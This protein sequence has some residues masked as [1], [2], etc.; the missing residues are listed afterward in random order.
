MK[1]WRD[2][3]LISRPCPAFCRLQY[4]TASDEKLG[5]GWERGER[6]ERMMG[7]QVRG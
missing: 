5:G 6:D 7:K 3:S 1:N 4:S 2:D